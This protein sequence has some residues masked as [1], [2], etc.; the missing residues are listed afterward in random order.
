MSAFDKIARGLA[1]AATHARGKDT[2]AKVHIIATASPLEKAVAKAIAEAQWDKS[3]T[4]LGT[5]NYVR[6]AGWETLMPEARA[7]IAAL[8][9]SHSQN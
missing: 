8:R 7:A 4:M 5:P 6:G 1:E 3:V 2:G 9:A